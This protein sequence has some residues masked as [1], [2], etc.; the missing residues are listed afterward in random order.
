MP[1]VS[2]RIP[3]PKTMSGE[4]PD[5]HPDAHRDKLSNSQRWLG[6]DT[7]QLNLIIMNFID[8]KSASRTLSN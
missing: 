2:R 3:R 8:P 7:L 5:V 6:D 1:V 4:S